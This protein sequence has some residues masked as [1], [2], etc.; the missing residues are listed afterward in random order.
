MSDL[1]QGMQPTGRRGLLPNGLTT[2]TALGSVT[3][4]VD[5]TN[6]VLT[7]SVSNSIFD[8]EGPG[9]LVYLAVKPASTSDSPV[10]KLTVD[11]VLYQYTI[12]TGSTSY[13]PLVYAHSMDANYMPSIKFARSMKL[14][15]DCT[16]CVANGN[17]FYKYFDS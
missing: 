6:D 12:P 15:I 8:I 16:A 9:E 3:A 10:V 4:P 17:V 1:N 7:N 11:G 5:Q 13:R 2:V 14:E